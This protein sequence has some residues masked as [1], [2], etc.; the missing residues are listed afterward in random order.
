MISAACGQAVSFP[1]DVVSRRMVVERGGFLAVAR[2]LFRKSGLRGFYA[3]LRATT[4]KT[5]PMSSLSFFTYECAMQ[6]LAPAAR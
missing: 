5:I 6:A 3:G 2:R 1:L 4:V